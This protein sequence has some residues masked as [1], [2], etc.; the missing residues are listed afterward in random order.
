MRAVPKTEWVVNGRFAISNW[1][2]SEPSTMYQVGPPWRTRKCTDSTREW[3]ENCGR[4]R[5]GHSRKTPRHTEIVGRGGMA[6]Y[7]SFSTAIS[8][9]T[10]GLT[11]LGKERGQLVVALADIAV[12]N[13]ARFVVEQYPE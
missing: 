3:W 11:T 9:R 7:C 8:A 1:D 12:E 10:A 13:C 4:N 2:R 5:P 6:W